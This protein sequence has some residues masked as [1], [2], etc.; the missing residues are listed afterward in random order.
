MRAQNE[1]LGAVVRLNR[2]KSGHVEGDPTGS[3]RRVAR[4]AGRRASARARADLAAEPR[5]AA[6]RARRRLAG[7]R[8]RARPLR[9]AG[10]QGD[11]CSRARSSR[12]S[13]IPDVRASCEENCRRLGAD[14]V[15]VVER[16]RDANCRPSSTGFDRVLVDA[17]CSG[18]GVLARAARPALAR[19]AAAGAPARAA[20]GR[21]RAR[22]AGRHDRLLGLHD[23]RRGERGGRRR[24]RPAESSRSATSGRSSAIRAGPSSCSRCRT[25]TGRRASSSPGSE[26]RLAARGLE[27]LDPDGRGRALALRGRLLAP[28]RADRRAA[29]RG[30]AHLPLRRRR[31]PLRRAGHDRARSSCSGSRRII[32]DGGAFVDCHLMTETPEK[33]FAAIKRAGGDSV[34]VPLR[35]LPRSALPSSLGARALDSADRRSRSS[36]RRARRTPRTLRSR[37]RVDMVLVHEHRARLLGPGVHAGGATTGSA[38]VRSVLP[39]EV[40]VQVDGGIGRRTS[41]PCATPARRS[42]SRARRSS[43][44]RTCRAPTAGCCRSSHEPRT[45]ARA[46]GARARDDVPESRSSAPSSFARRRGRRRG[47]A[48]TQGRTARRGRSHS[49][50]QANARAARR[51]S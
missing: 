9:R 41:R 13:S 29:P 22:E 35:G 38:R 33:H 23:E 44:A 2:R 6:R 12:S 46:R 18:L 39:P 3:S 43:V 25:S 36:R 21:S 24:V 7:R 14:N 45:G 30:R 34:T 26:P 31:R 51:S 11:A 48:R 40:H 15:T 10:R 42:S 28:R 17:P 4:R 1:P 49:R 19:A 20:A 16:R 37:R 5:V 50:R 27:R 32:H 8:A 47:L